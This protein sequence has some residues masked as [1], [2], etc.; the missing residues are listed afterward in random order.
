M[1]LTTDIANFLAYQHIATLKRKGGSVG[2]SEEAHECAR[3]KRKIE[4]RQE[5]ASLT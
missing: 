4:K 3:C 2:K 1:F 5:A